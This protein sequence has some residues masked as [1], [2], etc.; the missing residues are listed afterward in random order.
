MIYH[1]HWAI[2]DIETAPI[3]EEA[4]QQ[5]AP[6]SYKTGNV[7]DPIKKAEAILEKH[8]KFVEDATLCAATSYIQAIG[9]LHPVEGI[10]L[11]IIDS[12]EHE[13]DLLKRFWKW[14]K[15]HYVTEIGIYRGDITLI[16]HSLARFD[17]PR[18]I[19]R[20]WK[21]KIEM[22]IFSKF[23]K[24][25]D[26]M[27]DLA[28]VWAMGTGEYI[29][30]KNMAQHFGL[31]TKDEGELFFKRYKRDPQSARMYLQNDL[32]LAEG[33]AYAMNVV[34]PNLTITT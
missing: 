31:G 17:M 14:Y 15:D 11:D 8:A 18:I 6:A 1:S 33:C 13:P 25:D 9:L 27:I 4:L 5:F 10:R 20:S 34:D 30:L 2:L 23:P 26:Y 7:K 12:P 3:A 29:S 22:P 19:Q 16:N 21:H 28:D 32:V 24:Y